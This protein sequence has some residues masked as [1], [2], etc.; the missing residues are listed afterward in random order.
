MNE[1]LLSN[2]KVLLRVISKHS[3]K[4]QSHTHFFYHKTFMKWPGI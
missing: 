1:C 3:Q 2:K 4:N